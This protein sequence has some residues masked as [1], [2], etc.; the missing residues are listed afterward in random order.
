MTYAQ[1]KEKE[2]FDG[3]EK[4]TKDELELLMDLDEE[5]MRKGHFNRIFPND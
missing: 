5:Y 1:V 2:R 3:T 4:L